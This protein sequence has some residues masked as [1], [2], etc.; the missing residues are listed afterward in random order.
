MGKYLTIQL[1]RIGRLLPALILVA[2]LL[3]TGVYGAYQGLLHRW[4]QGEAFQ[5]VQIGVVGTDSS[6]LLQRA[7]DAVKSMDSSQFSLDFIQMSEQQAKSGLE[8]GELSAYVVIPDD[9]LDEALSGN[10]TPLRFV[11]VPGSENIFS[12]VK[13]ELTGVVAQMLLM[14]EQGAFALELALSEHGH[15]DI[16]VKEMNRLALEYAGNILRRDEVYRVEEIGVWQGIAFA[17]N[18]LCGLYTLFAFLLTLPFATVFVRDHWDMEWVLKSKGIGVLKQMLC[19]LIPFVLALMV[20]CLPVFW[21]LTGMKG[22]VYLLP[23][24][25]CIA[26]FAYFVFS[27]TGELIS[28]VMLQLTV[29]LGMCFVS[30]C[31]YPVHFFPAT[32]QKL[33]AWLPAGLIRTSLTGAFSAGSAGNSGWML[34]GISAL[35]LFLSWLVRSLR[36]A[37]GVRG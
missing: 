31:M 36:M 3:L 11:S 4:E 35:L 23:G 16:S 33:S 30:G 19:Q 20:I 18:L 12:I 10:I 7:V 25:L 26:T 29:S 5:K 34:L 2:A 37:K 8:K 6:D 32:V 1:K 17:D 13:D 15:G 22:W 28:A 24:I 9:F 27:L 21:L 14:S